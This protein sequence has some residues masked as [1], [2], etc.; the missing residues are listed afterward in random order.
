MLETPIKRHNNKWFVLIIKSQ[1]IILW[2]VASLEHHVTIFYAM[3]LAVPNHLEL[4]SVN[5]KRRSKSPTSREKAVVPLYRANLC[6][7]KMCRLRGDLDKGTRYSK[8]S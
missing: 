1:V 8:G 5:E 7:Y 3:L 2:H 6:H 4:L